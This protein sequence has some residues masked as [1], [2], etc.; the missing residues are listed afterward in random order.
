MTTFNVTSTGIQALTTKAQNR[1]L[2]LVADMT[3][4][5]RAVA[6]LAGKGAVRTLALAQGASEA[7]ARL[8]EGFTKSECQNVSG[9]ARMV[10]AITG[11]LADSETLPVC[12]LGHVGFYA[13]KNNMAAWSR[14]AYDKKQPSAKTLSARAATA[15]RVTALIEHVL[16]MRNDWE[17]SQSS[18]AELE[19]LQD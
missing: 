2:S 18:L 8:C 13:Y 19:A 7:F 3:S 11:Q 6:A 15:E 17:Q 5:E 9:F 14:G 10:R 1:A 12:P 4:D 16:K